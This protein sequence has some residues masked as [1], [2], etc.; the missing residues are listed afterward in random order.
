MLSMNLFSLFF[1]IYPWKSI[2]SFIQ[3]NLKF[4]THGFFVQSIIENWPK[5]F[6]EEQNVESLHTDKQAGD[7]KS[8]LELPGELKKH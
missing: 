7:H 1:I 6:G 4:F 2:W 8:S 5:C 3:T